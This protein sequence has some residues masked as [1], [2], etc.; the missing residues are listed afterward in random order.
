MVYNEFTMT[1]KCF[2]GETVNFTRLCC[3]CVITEIFF[4]VLFILVT[5]PF[6]RGDQ[7][8]IMNEK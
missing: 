1:I 7:K 3:M 2:V 8:K 4:F 5:E 6:K